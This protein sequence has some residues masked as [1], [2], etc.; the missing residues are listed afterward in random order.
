M[1]L[2]RRAAV[3]IVVLAFR[4]DAHA[5]TVVVTP[6]NLGSWQRGPLLS[7]CSPFPGDLEFVNGP[8]IPPLGTGSLEIGINPTSPLVVFFS[9]VLDDV[10]VGDITALR[11]S[12][13]VAFS[14]PPGNAPRLL[15]TIETNEPSA[16]FEQLVFT[17]PP[18]SVITG[19]WQSWD[20][21]AGTWTALFAFPTPPP[22]TLAAY[23]AAHPAARITQQQ[24]GLAIV[25]GCNGAQSVSAVD[26]VGVGVSGAPTLFDFELVAPAAVPAL[27]TWAL[28]ALLSAL[29]LAGAHRARSLL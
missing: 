21:L 15:L 8:A 27:E 20:A 18:A 25:A 23:V 12:T 6:D 4:I 7:P 5:A 26:A 24:G 11:Y 17:P 14:S 19:G 16:P 10:P 1:Q 22:T 29:V 2:L 28:M 9:R 13:Y 3:F